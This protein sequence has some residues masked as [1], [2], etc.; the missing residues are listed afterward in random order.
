MS[1]KLRTTS[2]A[3]DILAGPVA[4]ARVLVDATAGNGYDT[5]FLANGSNADAKIFSFDIQESAIIATRARVSGACAA[6]GKIKFVNDCHSKIGEYVSE[7]IDIAMFNLGY[8]PG[9]DH[10]ITTNADTSLIAIS[11]VCKML[12]RGGILSVMVYQNH[13]G[14]EVECEAIH[15]LLASLPSDEFLISQYQM[16]NT[17]TKPTIL[18][19]IERRAS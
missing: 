19:L 18:F 17:K 13:I 6:A 12:S 8:L 1:D 3:H 14:G 16:I 4:C 5:L 11:T 15:G 7:E 9:A 2:V 10:D